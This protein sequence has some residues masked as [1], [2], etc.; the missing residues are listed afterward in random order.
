MNLNHSKKFEYL[1]IDHF[2]TRTMSSDKSGKILEDKIKESG[3]IL[4]NKLFVK[5]EPTLI[6]GNI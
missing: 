4:I 6:K 1:Y 2:D 5:D 3:H